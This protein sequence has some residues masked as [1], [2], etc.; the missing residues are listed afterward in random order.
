MVVVLII[1]ILL[2]VAFKMSVQ[3]HFHLRDSNIFPDNGGSFLIPK[4]VGFIYVNY[5]DGSS[6]AQH[7][8]PSLFIST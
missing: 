4:S 1:Y 2:E 8:F 5:S 6:I 7:Y 3:L